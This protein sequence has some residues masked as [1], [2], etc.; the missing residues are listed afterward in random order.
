MRPRAHL[1]HPS[2][3][4]TRWDGG[5]RLRPLLHSLCFGHQRCL[6]LVCS[7]TCLCGRAGFPLRFLSTL[8]CVYLGPNG[9]VNAPRGPGG[10]RTNYVFWWRFQSALGPPS[11]PLPPARGCGGC[12]ALLAGLPAACVDTRRGAHNRTAAT[13]KR[14][15]ERNV[16]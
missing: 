9:G 4:D 2:H 10:T 1:P 5:I 12:P 6:N 11:H 3:T 7:H 16:K 8:R 14:F 15:R 13:N